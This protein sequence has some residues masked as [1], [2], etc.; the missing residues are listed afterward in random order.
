MSG[1]TWPPP[2]TPGSPERP[3][4]QMSDSGSALY[5]QPPKKVSLDTRPKYVVHDQIT[6]GGGMASRYMATGPTGKNMVVGLT[7]HWACLV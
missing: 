4:P 6:G 7:L 1:P 5:R 2:K 3:V